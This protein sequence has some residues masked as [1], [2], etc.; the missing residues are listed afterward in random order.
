MAGYKFNRELSQ[1]EICAIL[2]RMIPQSWWLRF[3][4]INPN[5]PNTSIAELVTKLEGVEREKQAEEL[6]AANQPT[7]RPRNNNKPR[8]VRSGGNSTQSSSSSSTRKRTSSGKGKF[9]SYCK[10]AGKKFW[11]HN[12]SDCTAF[13][14]RDN[15]D[16]KQVNALKKLKATNEKMERKVAKLAKKIRKYESASDSGS[17]EE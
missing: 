4:S 12:T 6:A 9:C 1:Y 17:D 15:D 11:T 10:K 2:Q 14:D 8:T 3:Q 7:Q 5:W 13:N 16:S